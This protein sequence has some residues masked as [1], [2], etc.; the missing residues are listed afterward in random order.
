MNAIEHAN[1][2]TNKFVPNVPKMAQQQIEQLR[3]LFR[4]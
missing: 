1:L 4:Y 2:G 3:I